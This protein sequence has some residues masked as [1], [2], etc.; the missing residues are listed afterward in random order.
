[1]DLA[2][3]SLPG[4]DSVPPPQ[5]TA[6]TPVFEI[7]HPGEVGVFPVLGDEL[8]VAILHG[9]YRWLGQRLYGHLPLLGP[10]GFADRATQVATWHLELVGFDFVEQAGSVDIAYQLFATV[11]AVQTT[12][13]LRSA[14]T[15]MSVFSEDIDQG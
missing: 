2:V 1:M 8:D 5:L 6:D 10:I 15:D 3:G 11:K 14:V 12:I 9:F 13:G 4:W 7:T